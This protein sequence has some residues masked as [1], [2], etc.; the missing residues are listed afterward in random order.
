MNKIFKLTLLGVLW[1]S[2]FAPN[3]GAATVYV[4]I[5]DS[6]DLSVIV[7]FQFD[8]T[9]DQV[10]TPASFNTTVTDVDGS[11][12]GGAI[13]LFGGSLDGWTIYPT[14][15]GGGPQGFYGTDNYFT[16]VKT[17]LVEGIIMSVDSPGA[18]T[19]DNWVLSSDEDMSGHYQ[20]S[21]T[22]EEST[23]L[24]DKTMYTMTAGVPIPGAIW[25]LGSALI[26]LLGI[27]RKFS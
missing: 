14:A 11:G 21:W 10:Y 17:N 6:L 7:G 26:G 23:I 5:D 9:G 27:K 3:V 15:D 24:G 8:I 20:G 4:G 25:L 18:M 16:G 1:I 12:L 19:L 13:G 22:V 2:L